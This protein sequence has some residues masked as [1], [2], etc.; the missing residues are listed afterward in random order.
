[1]Q[2]TLKRKVDRVWQESTV[3]LEELNQ[4]TGMDA[5]AMIADGFVW[6]GTPQW[7]A[8]YDAKGYDTTNVIDLVPHMMKAR[9]IFKDNRAERIAIQTAEG[10]TEAESNA[11]CDSKPAIYGTQMELI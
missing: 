5:V 4:Y 10:M 6:C 1:M 2:V 9:A 3:P 7:I 11:Y 8:F